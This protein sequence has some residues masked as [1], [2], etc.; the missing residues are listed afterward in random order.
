M[1]FLNDDIFLNLI[2][3]KKL[4]KFTRQYVKKYTR[5][6]VLP[7]LAVEIEIKHSK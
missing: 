3:G 7:P 4:S 1:Q 2:K 5:E 6:L